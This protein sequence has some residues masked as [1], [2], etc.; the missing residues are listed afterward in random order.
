MRIGIDA[1][2]VQSTWSQGRG[3]GRYARNLVSALLHEGHEHTFILYAHDPLPT[4]T[5]PDAPNA[6]VVTIPGDKPPCNLTA[7][8]NVSGRLLNGVPAANVCTV[9]APTPSGKF[10]H[11]EQKREIRVV[12]EWAQA[13]MLTWQ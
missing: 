7:T 6:R 3:I 8:T 13:I 5:L 4:D 12:N 11:I 2:A 9:A 10:I 1:V